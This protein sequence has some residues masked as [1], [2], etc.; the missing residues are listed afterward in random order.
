[1]DK[2]RTAV[3]TMFLAVT[4]ASPGYAQMSA[5]IKAGVV[6]SDIGGDFEQIIGTS[7]DLKTGFSFGGFVGGNLHPLFRLQFEGQFIEK[8]AKADLAGTTGEF[9]LQYFELL[10]PATLLI[11][12]KGGSVQ[13]RLYAGPAVAFQST[14]KVSDGTTEISCEAASAP[15]KSVDFGVF[16]GGGVD[17]GFGKGAITFDALYNLG[18]TNI[19]DF[20]NDP[21]TVKNRTIQIV[22][23]YAFRLGS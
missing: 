16:F 22:A 5:G 3:A 4:L 7:T 10:L 17:I 12:V 8:G 15:T 13:P 23:G 19:N 2:Y 6:F 1:M 20:P 21:N 18:I 11:P 9:N 14:C